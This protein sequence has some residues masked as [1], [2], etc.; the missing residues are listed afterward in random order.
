MWLREGDRNTSFF[1]RMAN[2]HFRKNTLARIKINGVWLSEERELREGISHAFQTLLTDNLSWRAELDGLSFSTLNLNDAR[3]LELPF[4]EEE[5]FTALNNML[6]DKP[7]GLDDFT[8]A[9]WQDSWQFVKAEIME[10]FHAFFVSETFI[11]SLNTTFLV[12]IPKKGEAEDLKDFRPISLLGRLYKLLAKV[13]ANCLKRVV[14][15]LVFDAQNAFVKGRHILNTSLTANEI[16]YLWQKKKEK[17]VA[18]K[19]DIEKA[20][21]NI[22]WQFL[23]K[24]MLGMGFGSKWRRWIWWCISTAKF[25]VLVNGVPAGF[26]SSS[27]GLRQGGSPLP[28]PLHFGYGGFEILLRRVVAGGFISGCTLTGREGSVCSISHLLFVDDTLVFCKA[29]KD[30][31]IY[32]RWV[33]FW[34]EAS[35]GLE[36]NLDKSEIDKVSDVDNLDSLAT[37]LD[38]CTGQ[39]PFTYLG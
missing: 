3:N 34:F 32:L 30:Q 9:S 5:V 1:H 21:D 18:C 31:L 29:S 6:G 38:C 7:P 37:V 4:R 14:G 15:T 33:L 24:V 25:S 28:L 11:R 12:L 10:L 19:L 13:L 27:R 8:L 26:F 17:G 36:I 2:A 16:I 22:N 23:M 20:F 35:Y 39:L